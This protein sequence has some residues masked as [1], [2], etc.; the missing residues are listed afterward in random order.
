MIRSLRF[1][2]IIWG[3]LLFAILSSC[4]YFYVR[5]IVTNESISDA[6]VYFHFYQKIKQIGFPDFLGYLRA[7][8]G[9]VEPGLYGFYSYVFGDG[10]DFPFF[11]ALNLLLLLVPIFFYCLINAVFCQS[12]SVIFDFLTVSIINFLWYP[13]YATNLWTWRSQVALGL[14]LICAILPHNWIG[15][16]AGFGIS[17]LSISIHYSAAPVLVII[18]FFSILSRTRLSWSSLIFVVILVGIG[19]VCLLEP[20]K[21]GLVSGN[22]IWDGDN[23]TGAVVWLYLTTLVFIIGLFAATNSYFYYFPKERREVIIFVS[24]AAVSLFVAGGDALNHQNVMRYSQPAI[25]ALSYFILFFIRRVE[26]VTKRLKLIVYLL[27]GCLPTLS[28][29]SRYLGFI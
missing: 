3:S 10:I 9:K 24:L 7:V 25:V 1:G 20:V 12:R 23:L 2:R 22:G 21:T 4:F 26:G 27:L 29:L 11:V 18:L 8:S 6:R 16:L 5:V 14:A 13:S 19:C 17:M 15:I 28:S